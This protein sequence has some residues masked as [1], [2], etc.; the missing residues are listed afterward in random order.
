MSVEVVLRAG[1]AVGESPVWCERRG[2]LW[3]VDIPA[4]TLHAFDPLSRTNR[5][6]DMGQPVGCVGLTTGDALLVGLVDGIF[7]F[8]PASGARTLLSRPEAHLPCNRP[9]DAAMA[10]D[11][12]WFVG[13]MAQKPDGTPRGNLYR[14][15]PDGSAHHLL[16]GLHV[17]NGLAV[18]PDNRTLYLSDSWASVRRIWAFDLDQGGGISNRRLFF[19]TISR[20]G[21]PDGACIDADGGYW[22]AGIDG[23]EL[24]R[25]ARDGVVDTVIG[26]PLKK[27]TKP[28]FGGPDLSTL[29]LTSLG[30]GDDSDCAGAL[31]AVSTGRRGLPE[32]RMRLG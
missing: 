8:D 21:R 26:L 27:P 25:I 2:V 5:S 17:P 31:L 15:D 4:G 18:S 3:W 30:N 24:L 23:G 28:C 6:F 19:D 16:D 22:S 12:R 32:P 20:P 14:I 29:Y 7:L 11:G 9:N 10:R 13:T 1:A